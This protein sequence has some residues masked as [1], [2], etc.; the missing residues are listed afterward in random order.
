MQT[1]EAALSAFAASQKAFAERSEL[2]LELAASLEVDHITTA[3]RR[4]ADYVA[5]EKTKQKTMP[6]P[7]RVLCLFNRF[8]FAFRSLPEFWHA[9]FGYISESVK[10]PKLLLSVS[11][12]ALRHVTG[13]GPLYEDRLFALETAG[14]GATSF[15]AVI[16][17]AMSQRLGS[18]YEYLHVLL[19]GLAAYRRAF[20]KKEPGSEAPLRH[21]CENCVDWLVGMREET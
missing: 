5:F 21:Y 17:T 7:N 18:Y 3:F 6:T 12:R 1:E 4:L 10:L 14:R 11:S 16:S 19:L 13:S 20:E 15:D 8:T 2:E 9:F